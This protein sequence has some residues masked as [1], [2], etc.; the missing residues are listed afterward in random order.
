MDNEQLTDKKTRIITHSEQGGHDLTGPETEATINQI[1][2]LYRLR[3]QKPYFANIY[4]PL[5]IIGYTL[6]KLYPDTGRDMNI[7]IHDIRTN[8]TET[9]K[10][11]ISSGVDLL[12]PPDEKE[13]TFLEKIVSPITLQNPRKTEETVLDFLNLND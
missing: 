1:S 2:R 13:R 10:F 6:E 5:T 11:L 4:I 7:F 8:E 3:L 12:K 9:F